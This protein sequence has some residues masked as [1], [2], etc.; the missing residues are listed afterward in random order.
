MLWALLILILCGI[1]G[2]DIPHISFLEL[3]SFDKFVHAG[4]FFV[5]VLLTVRGF[6]LQSNFPQLKKLAKFIALLICIV[7][8]GSLEIMQGTLF[9]DRG[10]DVFDFIANTFGATMGVILYD[11]MEKKVLIKMIK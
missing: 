10:A 6:I 5:L 8:G 3:L 11:W 2:K 1:P 9:V 7:Y 4:I